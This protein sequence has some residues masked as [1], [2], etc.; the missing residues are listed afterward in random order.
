MNDQQQKIDRLAKSDP[1]RIETYN[2][3]TV[4]VINDFKQ[5]D[6]SSGASLGKGSYGEV[7]VGKW[8][9]KSYAIKCIDFVE[10]IGYEVKSLIREISILAALSHDNVIRVT[11]ICIKKLTLYILMEL[12]E[13]HSLKEVLF[14]EAVKTKFNLDE[15]MKNHI[16]SQICVAIIYTFTT[17]QSFITT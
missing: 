4:T 10:E 17:K 5:L 15:N 3:Q 6:F 7:I 1:P 14:N 16:T 9:K 11:A 13:G 2:F 8:L 12:F